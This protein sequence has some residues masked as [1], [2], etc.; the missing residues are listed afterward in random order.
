MASEP[1]PTRRLLARRLRV[2]RATHGWSQETLAALLGLHRTY[3]SGIERAKR[4]LSRI[5]ALRSLPASRARDAQG[6]ASVAGGRMP[7]ATGITTSLYGTALVH[8]ATAPCVALPSHIPVGRL[9][10]AAKRNVSLDN[11]EKLAQAF[12]TGLRLARP[13][14]GLA[15][16]ACGFYWE[17]ILKFDVEH[18]TNDVYL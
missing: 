3:I 10:V 4:P 1:H 11:L 6:C 13:R 5:H 12:E 9:Y 18:L 16:L 7:E 8:P 17:A 15:T 2:L 14:P